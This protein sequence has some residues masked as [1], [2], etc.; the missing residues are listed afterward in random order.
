M[1]C[2]S[3][4]YNHL[5]VALQS[6]ASPAGRTLWWT[7]IQTKHFQRMDAS[8]VTTDSPWASRTLRYSPHLFFLPLWPGK[9][10][11]S[12]SPLQK[13]VFPRG[14]CRGGEISGG[15]LLPGPYCLGSLGCQEASCWSPLTWWGA[16]QTKQG[17][18]TPVH[19]NKNGMDTW[20]YPSSV[21]SRI[22]LVLLSR[23]IPLPVSLPYMEWERGVPTLLERPEV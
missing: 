12:H 22:Q 9:P 23:I 6:A 14:S 19:Q 3:E 5:P 16:Q 4:C 7:S 21:V 11:F 1:T 17:G 15:G 2:G 13:N 8:T 18:V 20:S 10:T